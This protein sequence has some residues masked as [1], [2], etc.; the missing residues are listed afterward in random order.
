M[1]VEEPEDCS[2]QSLTILDQYFQHSD[3]HFD[4]AFV[5]SEECS[6]L[7]DDYR[8]GGDGAHMIVLPDSD[9]QSST[10][11]NNCKYPKPKRA[12]FFRDP[13]I[14]TVH[15]ATKVFNN[16][17]YRG[18]FMNDMRHGHGI[19]RYTSG[20]F[21]RYTYEGGWVNDQKHGQ[22]RYYC[23]TAVNAHSYVGGFQNG[24]FHGRGVFTLK[25]GSKYDGEWVQGKREGQ[26]VEYWTVGVRTDCTYVG[27]YV[28]NK[29]HGHGVYSYGMHAYK[30]PGAV[31][32]GP[33]VLSN[34]E[35]EGVLR[36]ANGDVF[37]GTFQRSRRQGVGEIKYAN[38]AHFKGCFKSDKL[39]GRGVMTDRRGKQT[40]QVWE[41][42]VLKKT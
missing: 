14:V 6:H 12:K 8:D 15:R 22:G 25:S 28:D 31:Y 30:N 32:E 42:D 27:Q 4:A 11:S 37:T 5:K 40:H 20:P 39:S 41:D 17:N 16:G 21:K 36:F 10:D 3:R 13:S 29:M 1:M 38:G 23:H 2:S 34:M 26:G 19:M 35:G 24:L 18:G 7:I 9:V 33:F